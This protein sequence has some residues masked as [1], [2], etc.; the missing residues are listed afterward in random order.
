MGFNALFY[1][2]ENDKSRRRIS[3][4]AV[5]N[6]SNLG[7]AGLSGSLARTFLGMFEEFRYKRIGIGCRLQGGTCEMVGVGE[8]KQGYYLVEGSGLPRIDI[9]GYNRTADWM[10]LVEQLKQITESGSPVIE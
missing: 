8:T 4:K 7:G 1:T 3:Q 10:R 6:I 2:P 5:D 9:I